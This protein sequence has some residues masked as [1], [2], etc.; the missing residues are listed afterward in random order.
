[1]QFL[2]CFLIDGF[3]NIKQSSQVWFVRLRWMMG[4]FIVLLSAS[5]LLIHTHFIA[6]YHPVFIGEAINCLTT[7]GVSVWG[8]S[9]FSVDKPVIKK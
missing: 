1:M 6:F 9:F 2:I 3:N 5:K 7:V 8:T 4:L